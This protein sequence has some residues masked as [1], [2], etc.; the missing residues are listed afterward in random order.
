MDIANLVNHLNTPFQM[1]K[2]IVRKNFLF[3]KGHG[4]GKIKYPLSSQPLHDGKVNLVVPSFCLFN[5][6]NISAERAC[7]QLS[8]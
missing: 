6:I 8:Q 5:T 1:R 3:K 4:Q 7:L 2:E